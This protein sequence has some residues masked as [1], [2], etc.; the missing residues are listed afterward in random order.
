HSP[1]TPRAISEVY[2]VLKRDGGA[3]IMMYHKHSMVGYMLWLRY[4]FLKLH[5]TMTLVETYAKHLESP[6]T[7][8]YSIKEARGLFQLFRRVEISTQLTHGDLR[9][10]SAGR[11]HRGLALSVARLIWPRAIIKRFFP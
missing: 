10:S 1:D 2:R 3:R 7:K 11:R 6:G 4:A 9:T 5:P 8:A